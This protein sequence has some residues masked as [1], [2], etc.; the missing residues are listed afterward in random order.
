V[1]V[2][3]SVLGLVIVRFVFVGAVV[4]VAVMLGMQLARLVC[5]MGGMCGMAGGD[6]GM[7]TGRFGVARFMVSGRFA[8]ML[9]GEIMVIGGLGMVL[10]S[11]VN[12]V[13]VN[14]LSGLG[15]KPKGS[16]SASDDRPPVKTTMRRLE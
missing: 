9:G 8:V 13:H 4:D 16:R 12:R 6:M 7:M 5:V 2:V 11:L 10:V 1:S 15:A 14:I 3:F